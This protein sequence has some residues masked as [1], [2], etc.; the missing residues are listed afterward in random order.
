MISRRL[1]IPILVM[2]LVLGAAR[3]AAAGLVDIIME[4]SGPNM[5][6]IPFDCKV[7]GRPGK[8]E[9]HISIFRLP[10]AGPEDDARFWLR[11]EGAI[12]TSTPFKN[13][14]DWWDV[15]MVAFEP[16]YELRTLP[17]IGSSSNFKL[18][19]GVGFAYNF[20]FG[21]DLRPFNNVGVKFRLFDIDYKR[22]NLVYNVRLYPNGFDTDRFKPEPGAITA[23]RREFV[24]GF[25]IRL[26]F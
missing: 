7:S 5:L 15:G 21:N 12:Y 8:P 23:Q 13:D 4:M 19:H 24:N 9:C 26:G 16:I 1:A 18:H 22:W 25:T 20:F 10:F 3:D 17:K 11:L 6:G 2:V 14:F